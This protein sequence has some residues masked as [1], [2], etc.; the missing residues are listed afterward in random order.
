MCI[1]I[2][3]TTGIARNPVSSIE[4]IQIK[5]SDCQNN[6]FNVQYVDR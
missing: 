1:T 2:H 6:T 4:I 5:T 3:I